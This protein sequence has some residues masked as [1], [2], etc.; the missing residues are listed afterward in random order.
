MVEVKGA[1]AFPCQIEEAITEVEG[2]SENYQI[3]KA[4]GDNA[5]RDPRSR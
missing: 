5:E 3:T 2:V 1:V 4:T